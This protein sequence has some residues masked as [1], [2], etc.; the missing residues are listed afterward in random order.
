MEVSNSPLTGAAINYCWRQLAQRAG[1]VTNALSGTGFDALGLRVHYAQPEQV[2][3]GEAAVVV[4]PC[5]KAAWQDLLERSSKSLHWLPQSKVLPPSA[6]PL[7]DP[8]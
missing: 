2:P 8:S 4:V 6:P 3:V 1:I 7:P 5:Q